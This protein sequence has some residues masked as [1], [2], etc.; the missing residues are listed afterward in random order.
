MARGMSR[1][2]RTLPARSSGLTG[3]EGFADRD[4]RFFRA[5]ARNQRREWFEIHR[6]EYEEGWLS[7]MKALLAEVR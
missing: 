7:P 3:F 6:R 2:A 4:A 5:L 1:A